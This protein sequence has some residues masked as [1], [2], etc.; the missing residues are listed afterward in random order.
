M[1]SISDFYS[2]RYPEIAAVAS[3][4]GSM[5][6]LIETF[7]CTGGAM[8]VQAHYRKSPLVRSVR[9]VGNSSRFILSAGRADLALQGSHFP[10]GIS[11]VE[12]TPD[13]IG[14]SYLGL[15]GGGVGASICRSTARGVVRSTSDPS[16]GGKQAGS[17]IW[18][19]RRQRVIIGVDDTDT[20]EEGATWTLV[21]NIA[22]SVADERSRYL[23]HT[24]V[25]LFPVPYRTKN[26]VAI[27]AEF[28][29]SEPE[30]LAGRFQQVLEEKT[31]SEETG[32]AVFTGFDP[33]PLM[34]FARAVKRG[35]VKRDDLDEVTGFTDVRIAGRGLI[36]A[37]AAIPFYTRYDEA[38]SL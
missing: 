12:L 4:D 29:S 35:E 27:A 16:G 38:L 34:P 3:E 30:K 28:A 23:S 2:I 13:E 25:Q 6:E 36:G 18:L 21:H 8:W 20:P 9:S 31:L 26:C 14:I 33:A 17:T 15:G 32:M 19:P 5:V 11:A 37:V 10:A 7:E 22:R 1:E 24:I